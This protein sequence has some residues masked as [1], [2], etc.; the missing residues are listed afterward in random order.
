MLS[1]YADLTCALLTSVTLRIQALRSLHQNTLNVT[2]N[3]YIKGKMMFISDMKFYLLSNYLL[4]T[5][6]HISLVRLSNPQIKMWV[7]WNLFLKKQ[8][9]YHLK[10][11]FIILFNGM[12]VSLSV[13]DS[14]IAEWNSIRVGMQIDCDIKC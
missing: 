13:V 8:I 10:L 5:K 2:Y 7:N 12:S 1:K 9:W 11:N 6:R 3:R 4:N 14:E